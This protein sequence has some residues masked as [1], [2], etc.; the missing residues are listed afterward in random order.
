MQAL[1]GLKGLAGIKSLMVFI[2]IRIDNPKRLAQFIKDWYNT[3][4]VAKAIF[5]I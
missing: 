5:T 1:T 3:R 4:M 2:R